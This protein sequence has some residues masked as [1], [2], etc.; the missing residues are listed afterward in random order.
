MFNDLK[1]LP[2]VVNWKSGMASDIVAAETEATI[3]DYFDDELS[4][5]P[6]W[7]QALIYAV[8]QANKTSGK[9]SNRDVQ[10]AQK[11]VK[12]TD[13][14]S[15]AAGKASLNGL[16]ELFALRITGAKQVMDPTNTAPTD[17]GPPINQRKYKFI[18]GKYVLEQQ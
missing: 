16:D 2:E 6:M 1:Y 3:P 13:L 4:N 10:N 11:M 18:N 12:L 9:L 7:E 14:V 8:A 17:G 5:I 15:K